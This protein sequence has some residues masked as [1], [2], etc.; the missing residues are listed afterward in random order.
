MEGDAFLAPGWEVARGKKREK[1]ETE[2]NVHRHPQHSAEVCRGKLFIYFVGPHGAGSWQG[3]KRAHRFYSSCC[4]GL[5]EQG[6]CV[7]IRKLVSP[8]P[9]KMP[10]LHSSQV[11][12]K[13]AKMSELILRTR[14]LIEPAPS[15]GWECLF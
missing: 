15:V 4:I 1:K 13:A 12:F 7:C 10:A 8:T 2:R 6:W 5:E 9:E 3:H 11:V 14:I